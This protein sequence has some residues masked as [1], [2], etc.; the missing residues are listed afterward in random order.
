M[1]Q[2]T[3]RKVGAAYL[4]LR[5]EPLVPLSLSYHWRIHRD[6]Q[7]SDA[8]LLGSTDRRFRFL[9]IL[10]DVQLKEDGL[11]VADSG[12]HD[13]LD[14]HA[15][16]RADDLDK[17]FIADACRDRAFSLG[18]CQSCQRRWTYEHGHG[19]FLA[20]YRRP[21]VDQFDVSHY[22]GP[23]IDFLKC[24]SVQLLTDLVVGRRGV[25]EP[26][27]ADQVLFRNLFKIVEIDQAIQ[28]R[29]RISWPLDLSLFLRLD[30]RR[31][32]DLA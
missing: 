7:R 15:R 8:G 12:G 27:V 23:E 9:D 1:R 26:S 32:V 14:R 25:V 29:N 17:T 11:V 10:V 16:T 3:P 4:D 2:E 30:Y 5:L 20:Q 31:R 24:F 13:A 22:P 6:P 28:W 21:G 19:R 18:M